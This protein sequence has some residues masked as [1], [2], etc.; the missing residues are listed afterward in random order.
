[1]TAPS[2]LDFHVRIRDGGIVY[3][4]GKDGKPTMRSIKGPLRLGEA[5]YVPTLFGPC[6]ATVTE[7]GDDKAS[8]ESGTLLCSLDF[9]DDDRACWTCST[10]LDKRGLKRLAL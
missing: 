3:R 4:F 7:C 10:A 8:A 9:G 1:M 2:K 6:R 5:L